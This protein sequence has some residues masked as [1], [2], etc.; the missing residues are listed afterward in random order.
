VLAAAFMVPA[1]SL[2]G[3]PPFPG[4]WGKLTLVQ[5]GLEAEQFTIVAVALIVGLF[6]LLVV[7]QIWSRAF[8]R[9]ATEDDVQASGSTGQRWA[10]NGPIVA[11]AVVLLAIGLYAQPLYGLAEQAAANLVDTQAYV[12]AVLGPSAGA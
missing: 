11:L 2:A 12:E 1:F 5:A 3:F 6:T 4:F 10:L 9:P 7:A 8:W